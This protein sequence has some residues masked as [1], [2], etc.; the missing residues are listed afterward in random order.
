MSFLEAE[1]IVHRDL[2]AR[3]VLLFSDAPTFLVKLADF[4]CTPSQLAM[5]TRFGFP[6][7]GGFHCFTGVFFMPL[8]VS[9][10][11]GGLQN[12]YR[13]ATADEEVPFRWVQAHASRA[14]HGDGCVDRL[15]LRQV[16]GA[17]SAR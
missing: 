15:L 17:G 3:N 12:Y 9:R 13:S 1:G 4:G 10:A 11:I 6:F 2:A 5:P 7:S 16:D 8:A 14:G